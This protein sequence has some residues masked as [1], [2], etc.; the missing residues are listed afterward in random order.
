MANDSEA[1]HNPTQA[2]RPTATGTQE[3]E[4]RRRPGITPS[5]RLAWAHQWFKKLGAVAESDDYLLAVEEWRLAWRPKRVKV[6]LVAESHVAEADGDAAVRVRLPGPLTERR[7][8]P[9]SYVRL[10]YCLGYGLAALCQPRPAARTNGTPEFWEI[11]GRIA[12]GQSRCEHH[13]PAKRLAWRVDVLE[14]LQQR[15]IWLEDAAPLGVYLPSAGQRRRI[16]NDPKLLAALVHDGYENVVWPE[17]KSDAPEQIW[18]IG[19]TVGRALKGLPGIDERR[20]IIQPGAAQRAG[21]RP[22]Y[23]AELE[24]LCRE[25]AIA[26]PPKAQTP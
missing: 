18:V 10:V 21:R 20:F 1:E 12:V 14:R 25:L 2:E 13:S 19:K 4:E 22:E 9:D 6:L 11:F 7:K 5:E 16:T 17:V 26:A 24:P 3:R 23:L 15:G 8:L